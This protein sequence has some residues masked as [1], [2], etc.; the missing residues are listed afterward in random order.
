MRRWCL[1]YKVGSLEVTCAAGT[2]DSI[3]PS[4]WSFVR[5]MKVLGHIIQWDGGCQGDVCAFEKAAWC[6][7]W[8]GAGS[9]KGKSLPMW[10]RLRDIRLVVAPALSWRA[11]WWQFNNTLADRVD[12]VQRKI[13]GCMIR[14]PPNPGESISA[15]HLRRG[16]ACSRLAASE[17]KWSMIVADRITT[18][19]KHIKRNHLNTWP[20][21]LYAHMNGL[22][23]QAKRI[24]MGSLSAYGGRTGTRST[25]GGP[26]TRYHEGVGAAEIFLA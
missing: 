23:F 8:M 4:G 2:T 18:W 26:R 7:F 5:S 16:R 24:T 17:G 1:Q 25:A 12:K 10:A 6:R 15:Y 19:S 14:L 11:S 3:L 13:Y 20:G 9:K 21:H 22:W